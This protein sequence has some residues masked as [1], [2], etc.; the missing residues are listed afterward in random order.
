[1]VKS[2]RLALAVAS[3]CFAVIAN[4]QSTK[5]YTET[6]V[7]TINET[8]SDPQLSTV[9]VE[10]LENGNINFTLNDFILV[11]GE[12]AMPIG[13]ISVSNLALTDE[14][15]CKSFSFDGMINILPGSKTIVFG[16]ETVEMADED[17]TGPMLG[18]IPV[19]LVGKMTD[20][21]LF[22][23][24]NIT[25]EALGQDIVVVLGEEILD[26]VEVGVSSIKSTSNTKVVYDLSG[27]RVQ[28]LVKGNVYVI[29]GKKV[30]K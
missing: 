25:M 23:T 27:R 26:P 18:E 4:A 20:D 24:I 28:N 29:D 7:V 5:S 16:G 3:M 2:L 22:V 30:M 9:N 15:Y 19:K 10:T 6:L 13:N 14:G 12:D 21:H 8:S 17:W 11:V 1:M